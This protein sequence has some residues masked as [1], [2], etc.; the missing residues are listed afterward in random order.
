MLELREHTFDNYVVASLPFTAE[1]MPA[2]RSPNDQMCAHAIPTFTHSSLR[3]VHNNLA[4]NPQ[5]F[6]VGKSQVV[7]NLAQQ[8]DS[9]WQP[10]GLASPETPLPHASSFFWKLEASLL[11]SLV[12]GGRKRGGSS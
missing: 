2:D 12:A 9:D 6:S 4:G 5:Q 10:V 11:L 8:L 7:M 1:K 3:K